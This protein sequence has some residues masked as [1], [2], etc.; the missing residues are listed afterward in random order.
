MRISHQM[1][2]VMPPLIQE[3]ARVRAQKAIRACIQEIVAPRNLMISELLQSISAA[4][5]MWLVE[6]IIK[7]ASRKTWPRGGG[8]VMRLSDKKRDEQRIE[9]LR[10]QPRVSLPAQFAIARFL[11]ISQNGEAL[12]AH[13][14]IEI[15]EN[16][17]TSVG[18]Y[19]LD[20]RV[21]KRFRREV[22]TRAPFR[23]KIS[24]GPGGSLRFSL[25]PQAYGPLV[26]LI[27]GVEVQ[28]ANHAVYRNIA[29]RGFKLIKRG[30]SNGSSELRQLSVRFSP[31]A[32]TQPLEKNRVADAT[33]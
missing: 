24:P 25:Y 3:F 32:S 22:A 15:T 7:S 21:E 33:D 31:W 5:L 9:I 28:T 8:A 18:V 30:W 4:G 2:P 16:R 12:V 1:R 6:H 20:P 23:M 14:W 10:V 11:A 26:I 17:R 29:I 13:F 27:R 19:L